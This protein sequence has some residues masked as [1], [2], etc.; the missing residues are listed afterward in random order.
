MLYFSP[1][2]SIQEVR[3]S[4]R[5]LLLKTF[6]ALCGLDSEALS[7]LL[8]S[9]LPVELA[10]DMQADTQNIQKL[11]FSALVCTMLLSSGEPIPYTHYGELGALCIYIRL[12]QFNSVQYIQVTITIL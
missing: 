5:L 2:S 1:H 7:N 10:R 3:S 6:G 4:I 9:I 12:C 11:T 8:T